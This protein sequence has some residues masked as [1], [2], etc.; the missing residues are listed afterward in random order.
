MERRNKSGGIGSDLLKIGLGMLA[1]AILTG[2][3]ALVTKE[4]KSEEAQNNQQ[5]EENK[6]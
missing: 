2:V 1:G 4:V 6:V 5:E 3:A